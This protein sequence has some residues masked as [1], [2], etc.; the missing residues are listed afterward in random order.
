[1]YVICVNTG[2][3][4]LCYTTI[5]VIFK[6]YPVLNYTHFFFETF[7]AWRLLRLY[8]EMWSKEQRKW[9]GNL[10]NKMPPTQM[11]VSAS[12]E[13][14]GKK[15]TVF[16]E[17]A[18]NWVF[19]LLLLIIAQKLSFAVCIVWCPGGLMSCSRQAIWSL[20]YIE[21]SVCRA[22]CWP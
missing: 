1:M 9:Q 13:A 4:I 3:I 20:C 2:V 16:L 15:G 22:K 12:P 14:K 5:H 21:F 7:I 11:Y 19:F 17:V 10:L 6:S 8:Y 18:K